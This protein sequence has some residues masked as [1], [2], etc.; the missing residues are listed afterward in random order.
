M[1]AIAKEALRS[2]IRQTIVRS[3]I[4][5]LI[6]LIAWNTNLHAPISQLSE[7]FTKWTSLGHGL[8]IWFEFRSLGILRIFY[9]KNERW[10]VIMTVRRLRLSH[11]IMG[12]KA[13][14]ERIVHL[15]GREGK[16]IKLEAWDYQ[17]SRLS[18]RRL[19]ER[20]FRQGSKQLQ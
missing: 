6:F 15:I 16:N 19:L 7:I 17:N 20:D 10:K 14:F 12:S 4:W 18:A 13:W 3:T 8:N 1:W 9:G 5:L 11:E 2:I